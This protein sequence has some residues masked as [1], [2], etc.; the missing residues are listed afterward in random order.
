MTNIVKQ[1]LRKPFSNGE[2]YHSQE[3][4]W[5]MMEEELDALDQEVVHRLIDSMPSR[6][7]AI[8]NA[9]GSHM[10]WLIDYNKS[11][12]SQKVLVRNLG[13]CFGI[14]LCKQFLVIFNC[15][16]ICLPAATL[17]QIDAGVPEL[18]EQ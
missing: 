9:G 3:Q 17:R 11:K 18:C 2:R 8:I 12:L 13:F 10:K 4:L 15:N 5:G 14:I 6:I 7:L 1:R 16:N